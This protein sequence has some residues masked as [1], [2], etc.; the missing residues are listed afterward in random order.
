[1]FG[2]TWLMA[3]V[4]SNWRLL[5]HEELAAAWATVGFFAVE[6]LVWAVLFSLVTTRVLL[7]AILGVTFA[8]IAT[9]NIVELSNPQSVGVTMNMY[10]D[11]L[12]WRIAVA[13]FVALSTFGLAAAGSKIAVR[14]VGGFGRRSGEPCRVIDDCRLI[15]PTNAFI[16]SRPA[17]LA[18]LATIA[19]A[20][21]CVRRD[22]DPVGPDGPGRRFSLGAKVERRTEMERT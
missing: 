8:S 22:V 15:S 1:M 2:L 4:L 12:P 13:A 9:Y 6:L 20:C 3:T 10:M 5:G 11:A 16:D 21:R 19:A 14:D 7:A 18:T 17:R